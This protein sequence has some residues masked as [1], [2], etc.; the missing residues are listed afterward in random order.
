[1]RTSLKTG[2]VRN[3]LVPVFFALRRLFQ[4]LEQLFAL[5]GSRWLFV[6]LVSTALRRW[7]EGVLNT[8]NKLED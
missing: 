4:V 8:G 5:V 6:G 1:M 2:A 3:G 7:Q